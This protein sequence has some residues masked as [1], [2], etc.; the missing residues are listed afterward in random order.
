MIVDLV[1]ALDD[2]MH[3]VAHTFPAVDH[4]SHRP[5][6]PPKLELDR[7]DRGLQAGASPELRAAFTSWRHRDDD[8]ADAVRSLTSFEGHEAQSRGNYQSELERRIGEVQERRAL[9][10]Q[11][12]DDLRR[13]VVRELNVASRAWVTTADQRESVRDA[14]TSTTVGA[15]DDAQN[16]MDLRDAAPGMDER[17]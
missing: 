11:A 6:H 15:V 3:Q 7:I 1:T 12:A 4:R 16:E 17:E 2:T 8:F 14:G 5:S 13:H 10:M 9:L